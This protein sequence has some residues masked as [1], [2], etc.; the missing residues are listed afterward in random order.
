[1]KWN[2]C[3]RFGSATCWYWSFAYLQGSFL[4]CFV[5]MDWHSFD[6]NSNFIWSYYFHTLS[7]IVIACSRS[8]L[9]SVIKLS[10]LT[11]DLFRVLN[12]I[13]QTLYLASG[14]SLH[15]LNHWSHK[16][17]TWMS[18]AYLRIASL[19]AQ[20]EVSS[21]IWSS[22]SVPVSKRHEISRASLHDS[23]FEDARLS[24]CQFVPYQR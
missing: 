18:A 8:P 10:L 2:W 1:M 15:S 20:F 6:L 3:E 17:T 13:L 24:P 5:A 11:I 7:L 14:Y 19:L 16:L 12:S 23:H 9:L 4:R 22:G 21:R